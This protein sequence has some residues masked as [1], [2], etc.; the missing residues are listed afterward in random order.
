MP[1]LYFYYSSMNA[2]KST[3]LL[4]ANYNYNERGLNTMIFSTT[5]SE[6]YSRIGLK[7]PAVHITDSID[8]YKMITDKCKIS[9]VF[10]DEA[11]F[12]KKNQ[13]IQL[14]KIVDILEIPVLC[15]GLRT[16]F[17]GKLF[18]GSKEL[19]GLADELCPLKSIC[20]CGHKAT[21]NLRVDSNGD[22]VTD[23]PQV[24]LDQDDYVAVCRKHH[25][26]VE[27]YD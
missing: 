13:V 27:Q 18:E 20:H 22:F 9:C 26:F 4:Q 14:C 3:A 7:A 15:Y 21:M 6:I 19:L 12:L 10:V 2:G 17:T 1:K 8:I 23:G 25:C 16:D 24:L 5:S 11:Q